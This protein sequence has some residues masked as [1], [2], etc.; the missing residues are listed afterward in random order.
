MGFG[1]L[2]SSMLFTYYISLSEFETALCSRGGLHCTCMYG[3]PKTPWAGIWFGTKIASHSHM[4]HLTCGWSPARLDPRLPT[5]IVTAFRSHEQRVLQIFFSFCW[6]G[7]WGHMILSL[8]AHNSIISNMVRFCWASLH[9]T[10]SVHFHMCSG[11]HS[12]SGKEIFWFSDDESRIWMG[13][14]ISLSSCECRH[15]CYCCT[16]E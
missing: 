15:L 4:Q 10:T 6:F 3:H 2:R 5:F 8:C 13:R 16:M 14:S 1:W 12:I 11:M 7:Q 9:Q